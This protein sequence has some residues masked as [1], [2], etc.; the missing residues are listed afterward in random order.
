M[1]ALIRHDSESSAWASMF[2]QALPSA[3]PALA[4][5]L[6]S[7]A[8][9]RFVLDVFESALAQAFEA[10]TWQDGFETDGARLALT[11]WGFHPDLLIPKKRLE[12]QGQKLAVQSLALAH[13]GSARIN[14]VVLDR[15][16]FAAVADVQATVQLCSGLTAMTGQLFYLQNAQPIE[17]VTA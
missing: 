12:Y 14:A 8:A 2:W 9:D 11:L 17:K 10:V 5:E 3:Q 6:G 16:P 7:A 4:A 1:P 15:L 13:V